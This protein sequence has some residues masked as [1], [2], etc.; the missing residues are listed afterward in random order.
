MLKPATVAIC[1]AAASAGPVCAEDLYF[2]IKALPRE[3][4]RI[5]TSQRVALRDLAADP[6]RY[7][8]K[9]VSVR[10]YW[11]GRQL[12]ARTDAIPG[13]DWVDGHDPQ[14]IGLYLSASDD[15][16]APDE[17]PERSVVV[18]TAGSCESLGAGAAMVMGYCHYYEGAYVA[19]AKVR[20][21]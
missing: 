12:Y 9:C 7:A 11:I 5:A 19:A 15:H 4:C 1:V 18:G 21:E 14:R 8:G 10:G 16:R 13:R 3:D 20:G 2:I 17:Y 6:A